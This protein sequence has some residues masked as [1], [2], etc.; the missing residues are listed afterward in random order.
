[1]PGL[2]TSASYAAATRREIEAALALTVRED[3]NEA[4]VAAILVSALH[5][6]EGVSARLND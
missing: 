2:N 1:M 5:L 6:L 3:A 4:E